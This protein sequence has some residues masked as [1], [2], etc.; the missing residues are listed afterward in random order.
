MAD[1]LVLQGLEL[2]GNRESFVTDLRHSAGL[3]VFLPAPDYKITP[4]APAPYPAQL[5]LTQAMYTKAIA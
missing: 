2:V 1:E 3:V 5:A 4:P